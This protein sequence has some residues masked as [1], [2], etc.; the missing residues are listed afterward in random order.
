MVDNGHKANFMDSPPWTFMEIVMVEKKMV[1]V[2]LGP[3][4]WPQWTLY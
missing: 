3:W 4:Q 1:K 2:D